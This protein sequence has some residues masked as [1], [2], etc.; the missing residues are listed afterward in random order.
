[1]A[2]QTLWKSSPSQIVNFKVFAI[3]G[4]SFLL[5]MAIYFPLCFIPMLYAAWKY[6]EV[7]HSKYE[8]TTEQIITIHG[9]L[10]TVEDR[11]QLFKIKDSRLEQP[12]YYKP[13][14]LWNII[15]ITEDLTDP[16]L[17]IPAVSQGRDKLNKIMDHVERQQRSHLHRRY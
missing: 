15:L 4:V 17:I 8:V 2:A 9:V 16:V 3:C 6:Y 11:M 13:M 1:M 7:E 14:G 12:F 10:S 5:T